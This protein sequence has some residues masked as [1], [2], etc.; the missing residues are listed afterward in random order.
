MTSFLHLNSFVLEGFHILDPY[1]N[2]DHAK[3][4]RENQGRI[5]SSK[6][7]GE[8]MCDGVDNLI[9]NTKG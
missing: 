2:K 1:R 5:K 9:S 7:P 8:N 4:R 6:S 3:C